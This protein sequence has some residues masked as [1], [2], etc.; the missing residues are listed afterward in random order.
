VWPTPPG[1]P[2]GGQTGSVENPINRPPD[3]PGGPT[4][5]FWAMAYFEQL[6][7]WVWVWVPVPTPKGGTPAGVPGKK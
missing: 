7:G 3:E 6:N 1:A 2:P 5:G 4:Q